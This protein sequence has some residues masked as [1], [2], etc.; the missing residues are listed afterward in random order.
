MTPTVTPACC[1]TKPRLPVD[2][3]FEHLQVRWRPLGEKVAIASA[4]GSGSRRDGCG[5]QILGRAGCGVQMHGQGR[6]LGIG[7]GP[8]G[9]GVLK[10]N[11][12]K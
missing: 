3:A 7:R 1:S 10:M 8:A 6:D 4:P 9:D 5:M 11:T 2:G 12:F